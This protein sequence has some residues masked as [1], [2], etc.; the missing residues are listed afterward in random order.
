MN[1][2]KSEGAIV[3]LMWNCL[4]MSAYHYSIIKSQ[5]NLNAGELTAAGLLLPVGG[6]LADAYFGRYKVIYYGMWTMWIGAVLNTSSVL[7]SKLNVLFARYGDV[8]VSWFSEIVVGAGFGAFQANIIQ[9]GIDQL[10]DASSMEITSFIMQYTT[11]LI[12]SGISIYFSTVCTPEYA[13]ALVVTVC[14]SLALCSS[15]LLNHCLV[16]EH[17]IE[18]PLLQIWNV[19][20]YSIKN[21]HLMERFSSLKKQGMLSH[22]NI[23]KKV[24]AG[25]FTSEQVEDVKTFIRV[26]AV[27]ATCSIACS[28]I[29]IVQFAQDKILQHLQNLPPDSIS[30][31]YEKL[32]ITYVTYTFAL[33]MIVAYQTIVHPM[34]YNYIQ[35]TGITTK[36]LVAVLLFL[37]RILALLGIESAS[38][39]LNKN[40]TVAHCVFSQN[41]TNYPVDIDYYWI[42][43]PEVFSGLSSFILILAAIEFICAQ[44]PFNMKG[45]TFGISYGIYGLATLLQIVI[46]VPFLFKQPEW[47]K[48]PLTCGIWYF[49][50]QGLIVL[51][52]SSLV[53]FTIKTYRRRVRS[54]VAQSNDWQ[55][56][57]LLS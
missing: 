57:S 44:A 21:K 9:F 15:F 20:K 56:I 47:E 1:C 30:G 54:N 13:G 35:K 26:M 14:L 8:W 25:P 42:I 48:A 29:Q 53:V 28:G 7:L 36:F 11:T 39:H 16:K 10:P 19:I 38:Y 24:Y 22:L 3:R 18:N 43:A 45:L 41:I 31:C 49:I 34:F 46:S 40:E 17:P 6:W 33:L 51:I 55:Q 52:G 23:A 2:L 4:A 5:G 37:V 50:M 12:V 27:I 32:S